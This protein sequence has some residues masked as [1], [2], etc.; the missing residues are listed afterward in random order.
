M[1]SNYFS[2]TTLQHLAGASIWLLGWLL[3]CVARS[4]LDLAN[5]AI[6]LIMI[7][8]LAA[9]CLPARVSAVLALTAALAF[10]WFFIPPFFTFKIDVHQHLLMLLVMLVVNLVII[11]L[12]AARRTQV[13]RVAR[14]AAEAELLRTWGDELH[15]AQEPG[16]LKQ[17]LQQLLAQITGVPVSL[18]LQKN[19]LLPQ[20][21]TS[22][23]WLLGEV[24]LEQ[25]HALWH[26][27]QNSQQ[28]GR[29]TGYYELFFDVYL[30]VRTRGQA[31]GAVLLH[32][33]AVHD[34]STRVHL[35]TICDQF[36][37]ALERRHS[38]LQEQQV[39]EQ[40]QTQLMRNN[41]LAAISHDYRTPLATITSAATSLYEQQEKLSATQ[42]KQLA[43]RIQDEADRLNKITGNILQLARLDNG[44]Q[45]SCDWQSAEEIVGDLLRR[46]RARGL[47]GRLRICLQSE[48]PLLWCDG[49][50]IGQLLEN[51]LDNALKYSPEHSCITLACQLRAAQIVL[52]VADQG[53]G[54]ALEAQETI[55][56]PFQRGARLAVAGAG[57]G[58]ALCRAIARA[59]KGEISVRNLAEGGSCFEV[60]LPHVALPS[61][62][63]PQE[64]LP[65]AVPVALPLEKPL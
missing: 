32:N 38:Q 35:Q 24:N 4:R 6:V 2:S 11:M 1:S 19:F 30:P 17:R 62:C 58:L 43:R 14:H 3:L 31:I 40:V 9:T 56:Q 7:S 61:S 21:Q 41:L 52:S 29:G 16:E 10:D 36:G 64:L 51:L 44:G 63:F 26:C 27:L 20:A 22:D 53:G 28:L 57:V 60:F 12:M 13:E 59:H 46:W 50:L 37:N 33:F 42:S 45:I 15:Q 48:L 47:D 39:R 18:L 23:V 8:A 25:R 65:S 55:F 5:L 49:L 34:F 54:I